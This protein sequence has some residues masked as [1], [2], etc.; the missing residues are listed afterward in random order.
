MEVEPLRFPHRLDVGVQG[1][2][3]KSRM[4]PR[5]LTSAIWKD[6]VTIY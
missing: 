1:E 2:S 6:G 4:T 3:E 5:F